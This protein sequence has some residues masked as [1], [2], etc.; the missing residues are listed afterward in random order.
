MIDYLIEFL[1]K[2]LDKISL[3]RVGLIIILTLITM[4]SVIVYENRNS[5]FSFPSFTQPKSPNLVGGSFVI[6]RE[7]KQRIQQIITH[8][9]YILGISVRNADLRLN[10]NVGVYYYGKPGVLTTMYENLLSSSTDLFPLWSSNLD[11]NNQIIRL[12]GGDFYCLP[13]NATLLQSLRPDLAVE[14]KSVCRVSLPPY[15]GYFTGFI[16]IYTN[17]DLTLD[18][19]QVLQVVFKDLSNKIYQ[20]DVVKTFKKQK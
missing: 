12:I 3:M 17:K 19:M 15:F 1:A 8:T 20:N 4:S 6:G 2:V 5:F 18:E 11:L 13:F 10:K 16:E 14:V 7:T 9:D